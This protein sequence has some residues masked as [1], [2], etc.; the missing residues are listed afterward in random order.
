MDEQLNSTPGD[1]G[2]PAMGAG[3][4]FDARDFGAA[5]RYAQ[6]QLSLDPNDC[7]PL[8]MLGIIAANGG[9]RTRAEEYLTKAEQTTCVN[10][11]NTARLKSM[12]G[13]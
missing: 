1:Y 2:V 13:K 4:A 9:D 5:S 6:R 11:P 7:S 3:I 10:V 8:P 12:L